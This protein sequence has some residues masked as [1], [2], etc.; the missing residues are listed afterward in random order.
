MYQPF[1]ENDNRDGM[2]ALDLFSQGIILFAEECKDV[3]RAALF[4]ISG[5][6]DNVPRCI[7]PALHQRDFICVI[8]NIAIYQSMASKGEGGTITLVELG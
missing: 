7:I 5:E 8:N 3:S 4:I 6:A 2:K 1:N